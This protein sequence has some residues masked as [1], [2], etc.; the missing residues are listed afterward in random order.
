MITESYGYIEAEAKNLCGGEVNL[1]F[2]SVGATE[3]AIMTAV[4]VNGDTVK[5][6]VAR[7]PEIVD[8]QLFLNNMGAKVS[9]AGSDAIYISGVKKIVPVEYNILFDRIEAGTFLLAGAITRGD[10][11]VENIYPEY[12]FAL[13]DK[14]QEIGAKVE[15]DYDYIRVRTV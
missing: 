5:Y 11:N 10:V 2:P 15:K 9:G 6:N 12:L 14:L 13:T 4:L 7:E 1:D 8:L 3:N